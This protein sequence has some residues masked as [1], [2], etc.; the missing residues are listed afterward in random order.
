MPLFPAGFELDDLV[1]WLNVKSPTTLRHSLMLPDGQHQNRFDIKH[2]DNGSWP[3]TQ[4]TD[5][6]DLALMMKLLILVSSF[7]DWSWNE[8]HSNDINVKTFCWTMKSAGYKVELTGMLMLF[9]QL[10]NVKMTSM[11]SFFKSGV[12]RSV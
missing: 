5:P 11:D 6:T 2:L 3:A 7:I 8:L 4:L 10:L 1:S 9:G 12:Q